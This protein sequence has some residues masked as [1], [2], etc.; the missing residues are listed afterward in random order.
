MIVVPIVNTLAFDHASYVTPQAIDAVNPNCNRVWPGDDDGTVQERMVATLWQLIETADL[1]IDLHTGTADMLE[2]VRFQS[3]DQESRRLASTFG[4]DYLLTGT[5]IDHG[6][7]GDETF[8][9][10]LR[11]A[12]ARAGIPAIVPELSNSRQIDHDAAR[13]GVRGLRNVLGKLG[14]IRE[15]PA[16]TPP[17]TLLRHNGGRIGTDRSGIFESNPDIE[18]GDHVS[19]EAELG[20]VYCPTTF[21]KRQSV[22][23]TDAGVVYSLT[24]ESVVTAGEKVAC[25]A[26]QV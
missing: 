15:E 17:Q 14:I 20:T 18:V 23:T 7:E 24:R 19:Q 2:H 11:T 4:T 12:A 9:G 8:Q 6:G 21:K 3:G 13:R 5:A 10:K 22:T 1:V 16:A 25:I 26:V